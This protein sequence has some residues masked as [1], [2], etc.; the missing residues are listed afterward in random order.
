MNRKVKYRIVLFAAF[1]LNMVI[2]VQAKAQVWT[3][4]GVGTTGERL[5][6]DGFSGDVL[7]EGYPGRDLIISTLISDPP[8]SN[9]LVEW[10][11]KN[12][13]NQTIDG[14]YIGYNDHQITLIPQSGPHSSAGYRLKVPENLILKMT[15]E[16]HRPTDVKILKMK[17]EVDVSSCSSVTLTQV[18]GSMVV[19]S[20]NG[21]IV[22]ER[23]EPGEL[24][25]V[26]LVT[27]NGDINAD[28]S[29]LKTQEPLML[30]SISGNITLTLPDDSR[31]GFLIKSISGKIESDFTFPETSRVTN[32]LTGTQIAFRTPNPGSEIRI[33]T[34]SGQITLKKQKVM[35]PIK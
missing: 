29:G 23:C 8:V 21:S 7:I 25:T 31:T 3:L 22:L 5:F 2:T 17:K 19:S 27:L 10:N 13:S 24:A 32:Q 34:V 1:C 30:N 12:K 6:L 16:E 35:K 28:F 9:H 33:A 20:E 26:S 4:R 11:T 14:L 18:S 15:G